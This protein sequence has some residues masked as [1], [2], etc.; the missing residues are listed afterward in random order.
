MD[1][2]KTARSIEFRSAVIRLIRTVGR[3]DEMALIRYR[4]RAAS[5]RI[6]LISVALSILFFAEVCLANET[7]SALANSSTLSGAIKDALGRPIAGVE[8]RLDHPDAGTLRSGA[9][10]SLAISSRSRPRPS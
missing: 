6:V 2:A 10:R 8:V 7:G 9:R 5:G 3:A 1:S 4:P